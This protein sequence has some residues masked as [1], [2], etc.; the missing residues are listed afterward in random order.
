MKKYFSL[1]QKADDLESLCAASGTRVLEYYQV[2]SNNDTGLTLTYVTLWS[3]L[4]LVC[5]CMGKR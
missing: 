5:F 1:Q 2:C 3:N 4:V